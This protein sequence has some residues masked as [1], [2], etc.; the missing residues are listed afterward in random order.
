M[1]IRSRPVGR[2]TKPQITTDGFAEWR[3]RQYLWNTPNGSEPD[4][5]ETYAHGDE[6]IVSWNALNN[7]I[8]DL[9][10]TSWNLEPGPIARCIARAV[11]LDHD[12]S[13]AVITFDPPPADLSEETRYVFRFKP[14]TLRGDF[15]PSDPDMS[16]PGFLLVKSS[17]NKK[18]ISSAA[19]TATT[20][21]PTASL[22]AT[23]SRQV[24]TSTTDPEESIPEMTPAAAAG[25]MIGL[26]LV[27]ALLV[28]AEVA[29]LLWRRKRRREQ[30]GEAEGS[31]MSSTRKRRKRTG[32][33]ERGLLVEKDKT[34]MAVNEMLWS[35]ELPGDSHW[36]IRLVYELQGSRFSRGS[37]LGRTLTI[38]SSLCEL[39]AGR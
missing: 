16:S 26:I 5:S 11:D 18:D 6:I 23:S 24:A 37:P 39:E 36:G 22:R 13:I 2:Q 12:G 19:E 9:W 28:G 27:V 33:G 4:F 14:P 31:E 7:S 34:G 20:T 17:P 38:N 30:A 35:P 25:L 8:Y 21:S 1:G 32:K 10:L 29:Y 15:V 3:K